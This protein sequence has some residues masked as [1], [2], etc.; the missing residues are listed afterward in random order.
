M[1]KFHANQPDSIDNLTYIYY[2]NKFGQIFDPFRP[3]FGEFYL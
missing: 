2:I 1:G 3:N